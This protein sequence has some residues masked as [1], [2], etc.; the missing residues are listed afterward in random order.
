M[1]VYEFSINF[2]QDQSADSG[3]PKNLHSIENGEVTDNKSK[4]SI[5]Q[6]DESSQ[7]NE[8]QLQNYKCNLK[9]T[10]ESI[11]NGNGNNIHNGH[12]GHSGQN[13][14]TTHSNQNNNKNGLAIIDVIKTA[15]TT[16]DQCKIATK[17]LSTQLPH[18]PSR[19]N[20]NNVT[21]DV[22]GNTASTTKD[23]RNNQKL[24]TKIVRL[25]RRSKPIALV[26][27]NSVLA[28]LIAISVCITMGL[29]YTIPAIVIGLI[30][31]VASSGLWYWLYIAA[32][33]APRDIR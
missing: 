12:N 23:E 7:K 22:N 26:V 11:C 1:F 20:S 10:N 21:Y 17:S 24:S 19:E 27:I 30:A 5:D 32:V 13:N 14:D 3:A 33:T 9:Y 29:D 16:S 25:L 8:N 2:V 15:Y 4:H 6:V 31:I 18:E 28:I